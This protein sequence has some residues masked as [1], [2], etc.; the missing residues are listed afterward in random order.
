MLRNLALS[1]L[2][3][4]P[5]FACAEKPGRA[6][7]ANETIKKPGFDQIEFESVVDDNLMA[8]S[9]CDISIASINT[10]NNIEGAVVSEPAHIIDSDS[11]EHVLTQTIDYQNGDIATIKQSFCYLYNF[12][13]E[14]SLKSISKESFDLALNRIGNVVQNIQQDYTLKAALVD[15]AE[16]TMNLNGFNI[17]ASFETGLPIQ[18]VISSHYVEHG[19][20]YKTAVE[21]STAS[22]KIGLYFSLGG[23]E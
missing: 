19:L 15:V 18:S 23:E 22:T 21:N 3:T 8:L 16:L 7:D 11:G 1:L 10:L 17:N 20:V 13:A 4:V 5:G 2:I 12:E 6:S 14:Y 9:D